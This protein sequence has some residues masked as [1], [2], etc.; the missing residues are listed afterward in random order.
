MPPP[1]PTLTAMIVCDTIIDDRATGKKSAIGIFTNLSSQ[2]FPCAHPQLGIYF[3][4]TDAEGP[5]TLKIQLVHLD[6]MTILGEV[7]LP[8]YHINDILSIEDFGVQLQHCVFNAPGKYDFRLFANGQYLGNKVF[9]VVQVQKP[10][11]G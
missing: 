3:C 5:Y 1:H 8:E 4:V 11:E 6:T 9:N 10:Q 2:N 7:V